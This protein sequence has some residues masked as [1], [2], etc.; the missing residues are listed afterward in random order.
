MAN[1]LYI[2]ATGPE[3]GKITLVL[4][5][6]ETLSRSISN[7]GFFRPVIKA[8]EPPDNDIQLVLNRYNPRLSYSRRLRLHL[9]GGERDDRQGAIQ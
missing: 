8:V 3:S 4:G 9:C 6:M 7:I 1:N 2:A 5:V